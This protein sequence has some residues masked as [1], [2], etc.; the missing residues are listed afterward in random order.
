M[1][2]NRI[3]HSFTTLKAREAHVTMLLPSAMMSTR[4]GMTVTVSADTHSSGPFPMVFTPPIL[5]ISG[6]L[7]IHH[8]DTA[9]YLAFGSAHEEASRR[10]AVDILAHI[11]S[12]Y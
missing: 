2:E 12:L 7:S 1:L 5:R 8:S 11:G 10:G 9:H 6:P 4:A 3:N